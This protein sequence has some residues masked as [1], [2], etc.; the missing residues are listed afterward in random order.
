MS[1]LQELE[2]RLKQAKLDKKKIEQNVEDL[3][4]QIEAKK[5]KVKFGDKLETH[6]GS[7]YVVVY[8]VV[9]PP[10]LVAVNECGNFAWG[11]EFSLD[12]YIEWNTLKI[13]GNIFDN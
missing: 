4:K 3:E 11:R 9:R 2:Q 12:K 7:K 1:N 6:G 13:T 10:K 5:V 8:D